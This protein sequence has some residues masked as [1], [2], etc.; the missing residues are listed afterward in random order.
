MVSNGLRVVK[1]LVNSARTMAATSPQTGATQVGP[2][3]APRDDPP[4]E[5]RG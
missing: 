4:A 5:G 1:S 3:A 2:G